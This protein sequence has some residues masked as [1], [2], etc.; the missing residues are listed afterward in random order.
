MKSNVGKPWAM[1]FYHTSMKAVETPCITMG[2]M[3]TLMARL[4]A[5]TVRYCGNFS[6]SGSRLRVVIAFTIFTLSQG[7]LNDMNWWG[8]P[9]NFVNAQ[10]FDVSIGWGLCSV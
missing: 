2:L 3:C 1:V 6:S 8:Y 10:M 9:W 7:V 5:A 4:I